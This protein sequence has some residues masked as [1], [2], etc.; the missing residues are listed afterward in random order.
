MRRQRRTSI[1]EAFE[2][3]LETY[4]S[5]LRGLIENGEH[6]V[7]GVMGDASGP[8]WAYTIGLH[9]AGLPELIVIGALTFPDQ[10]GVL[11]QLADEMRRHGPPQPGE[12]RSGI[13]VGFEI[14]FMEVEDP[15]THRF[16]VANRLQ[17]DFRALQVVWPDHD[18]RFPWEP[19]CAI[20]AS[21][22]PL[23]GSP[24]G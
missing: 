9:A 14:S 20:T 7:Q 22:Q 4:L 21:D 17:S 16:A 19:G 13:L 12:R 2:H 5:H 18:N 10:H 23:L 3:G 6:A 8:G 24:P 11:N 1:N 15:S